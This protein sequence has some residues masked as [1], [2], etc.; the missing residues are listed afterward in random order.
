MKNKKLVGK[1]DLVKFLK[2]YRDDL[3]EYT[4]SLKGS[5]DIAQ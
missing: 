3:K 5:L 2:E 1:S 4:D